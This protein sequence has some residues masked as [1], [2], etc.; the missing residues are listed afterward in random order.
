MVDA[1]S[2]ASFYLTL[3][4]SISWH[5]YSGAQPPLLGMRNVSVGC[6]GRCIPDNSPESLYVFPDARVS[7]VSRA[8][9]RT[10][11][12]RAGLSVIPHRA[13]PNTDQAVR[14]GCHRNAR[15]QC[16]GIYN[17]TLSHECERGMPGMAE[18]NNLRENSSRKSAQ[19]VS[20]A[21]TQCILQLPV[22]VEP[23]TGDLRLPTASPD[24]PTQRAAK[25]DDVR[26][27]SLKVESSG[28]NEGRRM[29]KPGGRGL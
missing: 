22:R 8:G 18:V 10:S 12:D 26:R 6:L 2:T 19:P 15:C 25:A 27:Q 28:S 11:K 3:S 13:P 17:W 9:C 21:Q 23:L 20:R 29:T 16:L 24:Y 5:W 7:G 4:V 14:I 1:E